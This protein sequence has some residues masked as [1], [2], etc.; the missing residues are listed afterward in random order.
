[1]KKDL[2]RQTLYE[3]VKSL[4]ENES[5]H[6]LLAQPKLFTLFSIAFQYLLYRSTKEP[7]DYIIRIEDS[8][9]ANKL[10]RKAKDEITR[11]FMNKILLPRKLKY[12]KSCFYLDFFHIGSW[13][14]TKELKQNR[15]KGAL[16][17]KNTSFN[18]LIDNN[19]NMTDEDETDEVSES[20]QSIELPENF[21]VTSLTHFVPKTITIAY[22]AEIEGLEPINFGFIKPEEDFELPSDVKISSSVDLDSLK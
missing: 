21:F 11:K 19:L 12:E 7:G 18:P 8:M 10:T 1:M 3:S 13:A 20:S 5:K 4:V 2:D 16:V 14:I 9:L 17:V 22:G 6:I 15:I